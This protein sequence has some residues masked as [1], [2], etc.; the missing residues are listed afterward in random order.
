MLE[1]YIKATA[2]GITWNN[3]KTFRGITRRHFVDSTG[4]VNFTQGAHWTTCTPS[5]VWILQGRES[6]SGHR[7]R[8]G[9]AARA[10]APPIIEKRPCIYHFLPPFPPIF[11]FAH[12]I[13]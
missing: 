11:W 9:G 1:R 2:N 8:L 5:F 12:L 6:T 7:R 13:F 3:K 10:R 4:N